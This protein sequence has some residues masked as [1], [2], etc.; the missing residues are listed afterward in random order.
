MYKYQDLIDK[1]QTAL[2]KVIALLGTEEREEMRAKL[3]KDRDN[4]ESSI[5]TLKSIDD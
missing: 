1:V 5:S 3:R 2:D 4:L